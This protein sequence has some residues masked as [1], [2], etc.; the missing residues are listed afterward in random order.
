MTQS[1]VWQQEHPHTA[2]V[3]GSPAFLLLQGG[4]CRQRGTLGPLLV[5]PI[6]SFP[7]PKSLWLCLFWMLHINGIIPVNVLRGHL[8]CGMCQY[9]SPF[10]LSHAPSW[11]RAMFC[12]A[13]HLSLDTC[14]VSTS[15]RQ[16]QSGCEHRRMQIY[17]NTCFESVTVS[18]VPPSLSLVPPLPHHVV[19]WAR[20]RLSPCSL[21]GSLGP[22]WLRQSL[23]HVLS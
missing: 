23:C 9:F 15:G 21:P 11:G 6:P 1:S 10:Q 18:Q 16:G 2:P 22:F 19:M 3:Q 14:V 4:W 7:A 13:I 17:Q 20:L 12:L 5:I 8:H